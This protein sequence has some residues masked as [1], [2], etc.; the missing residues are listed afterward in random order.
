MLVIFF[1][2]ESLFLNGLTNTYVM[3]NESP[4][5]IQAILTEYEQQ[6]SQ[7]K[8]NEFNPLSDIEKGIQI[9]KIFIQRLRIKV[10]EGCLTSKEHEIN[11]FKYIK[12]RIVGDLLYY[13]YL[14][15]IT[16]HRPV[17]TI[18]VLQEFLEKKLER[19]SHFLKKNFKC[20]AYYNSEGN[21][22]CD[23]YYFVRCYLK[24]EDYHYHPYSMID[25][26]FATSKDYL[27]AEFRAHEKVI[28]Y[29]EDEL[30]KLKAQK[31]K[32][33][34][35]LEQWL[36]HSPF[37]WT[38]T[39]VAATELIYALASSGSINNGN[40][41]IKELAKYVCLFFNIDKLEFYRIYSDLKIRE[42][43]AAFIDK[44]KA[45]LRKRIDGDMS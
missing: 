3:K 6:I 33:F 18:Y 22:K 45:N 20:Y 31:K 5:V 25:T 30:L 12:P 14:K 21:K 41:D 28:K 42:N 34:K 15:E 7:I 11:F 44:L 40:V 10:Q 35:S 27:F 8:L 19:F 38:D 4:D 16:H 43:P 2:V 23:E 9:S 1:T 24:V 26:N 13:C 17:C 39:K 37:Y 29:L 32:T 36:S